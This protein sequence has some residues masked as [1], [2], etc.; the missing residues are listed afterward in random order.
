MAEQLTNI[1][2]DIMS[3]HD[4][5]YD[6]YISTECSSGS[7]YPCITAAEIG[8]NVADLVD[9]LEEAATGKSFLQVQEETVKEP[10]EKYHL[11]SWNEECLDLRLEPTQPFDL[12]K[13]EAV[14][15]LKELTLT[16]LVELG[17]VNDKEEAAELYQKAESCQSPD[18]E[19]EV[20][21]VGP[22]ENTIRYNGDER[23]RI[24]K[25]P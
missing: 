14:A 4:G 20:L 6:V 3:N 5:T 7:H 13:E 21:H 19:L 25:E 9:T 24:V 23:I 12:T 2:V 1:S 16:R 22:M 11:L 15:A 17:V 8:D 18:E 10:G